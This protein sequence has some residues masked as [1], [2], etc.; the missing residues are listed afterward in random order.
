[1]Q[2]HVGD[3]ILPAP[4]EEEADT[5]DC[6]EIK[7]GALWRVRDRLGAVVDTETGSNVDALVKARRSYK[8]TP[9]NN[10]YSVISVDESTVHTIPCCVDG[11]GFCFC[12]LC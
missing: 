5:C 1:M 9:W 11:N 12:R 4:D 2:A 3:P 6:L 8:N 7:G 10:H